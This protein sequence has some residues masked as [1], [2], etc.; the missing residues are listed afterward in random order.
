MPRTRIKICGVM[1][2][3]DALAASEAGA[4]AV[5]MILYAPGA[6]R[7]IDANAARE[8]AMKLPPFVSAIGVTVDCP[9]T[10][11]RQ[12]LAHVPLSGV[13]LHGKE[14]VQDVRSVQPTS[15]IKKLA[16]TSEL[17]ENVQS[18]AKAIVPN[19]TALLIDSPGE[20][21]SGTPAD[22]SAVERMQS[23]VDR[24]A[25]PPLV[26]A[27]GLTPESVGEVVRRFRPWAVDVSSGVEDEPGHKSPERMRAFVQA[28]READRA[29]G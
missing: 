21:G 10:R 6:A 27:G 17:A 16:A 9:P 29:A 11:V 4:D 12:L 15:A 14:T 19:L 5:G 20:G 28:V 2:V 3:D 13:Q 24:A 26:L 22:W 18:W 7:Q 1:T 8:I 25:L 23:A